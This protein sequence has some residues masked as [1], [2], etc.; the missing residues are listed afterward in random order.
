MALLPENG[1]VATPLLH[2]IDTAPS[3]AVFVI[4]PPASGRD[5]V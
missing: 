4:A 1:H 5:G 3:L 2:H